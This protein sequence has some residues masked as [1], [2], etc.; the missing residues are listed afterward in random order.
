M[1]HEYKPQN[2]EEYIE[3][4]QKND[5]GIFN[6]SVKRR[7]GVNLIAAKS[8]VN[9]HPFFVGIG[10][11]L[12]RASSEYLT[13]NG[14]P[15]LMESDGSSFEIV[16]KSYSSSLDKI[17]RLNVV[18]NRGFPK[19]PKAGWVTPD[20][21]F[22]LLDDILRGTIVCKYVDGPG[23][24]SEL[25]KG[26]AESCDV[27]CSYV[28]RQLD[29]GYY[30][31]HFCVQIPVEIVDQD[32]NPVKV[33]LKVEIQITTQLQEI[34]YQITHK[35]Y[36]AERSKAQSNRDAWKWDVKSNRFK[37]GYLAHTLHLLE[38]IVI[39]LRDSP[40]ECTTPEETNNAE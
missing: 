11:F 28:P 15:L 19:P 6:D 1:N 4:S 25:L 37:S 7:Y 16:S 12:S 22:F 13:N 9:D 35:H 20:N 34:M 27:V 24:L 8:A 33:D 10:S 23:I 40:H 31:Y 21:M 2:E 5:Y 29:T 18:W 26:Y 14:Y 36:I 30:A 38:A 3:W 39:E 17:F 32:F